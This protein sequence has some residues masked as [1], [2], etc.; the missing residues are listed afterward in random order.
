MARELGWEEYMDAQDPRLF[1]FSAAT[2]LLRLARD[3]QSRDWE[4]G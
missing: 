2:P 1:M 3:M 4:L